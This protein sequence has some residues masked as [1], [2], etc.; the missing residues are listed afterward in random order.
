MTIH[1]MRV[2]LLTCLARFYGFIENISWLAFYTLVLIFTLEA[3]WLT[4]QTFVS[5]IVVVKSWL[6]LLTVFG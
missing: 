3:C 4:W 1:T 5:I 2:K 6:A